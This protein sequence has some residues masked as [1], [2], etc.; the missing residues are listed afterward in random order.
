MTFLPLAHTGHWLVNLLYIVPLA[1][2][3]IMLAITM[4]RDRRA[5]AAEVAAGGAPPPGDAPDEHA[6]P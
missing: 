5:E 3:V 2:V 6:A 4:V 1:I